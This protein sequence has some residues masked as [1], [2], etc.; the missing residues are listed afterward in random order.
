MK[1][2]IIPLLIILGL[3]GCVGILIANRLELT[4]SQVTIK[5]LPPTTGSSQQMT[6]E[7][8]YCY[9]GSDFI[10]GDKFGGY[11]CSPLL[12]TQT[13]QENIIPAKQVV[14]WWPGARFTGLLINGEGQNSS[15]E[16]CVWVKVLEDNLSTA[17][18]VMLECLKQ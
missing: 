14:S 3:L 10:R 7:Y 2:I 4:I 15:G 17:N 12:S 9:E 8:S 5:F 18:V 16:K 13:D 1:K 6:V 11:G